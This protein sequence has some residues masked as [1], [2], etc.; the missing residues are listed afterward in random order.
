MKNHR[1]FLFIGLTVLVLSA[2]TLLFFRK[3]S[4]QAPGPLEVLEKRNT[5]SH[6]HPHDTQAPST[7]QG[8]ETPQGEN[9][10]TQETAAAEKSP[11]MGLQNAF[12]GALSL[13][14]TAPE[15]ASDKL[16]A[17]A[18]ELGDGD[19]KWTEYYHLLGHSIVNRPP[20][21]PQRWS[22]PHLRGRGALLCPER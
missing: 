6:P 4:P 5:H 17:I 1:S 16:H 13:S 8:E 14:E 18:A 21:G 20:R 7:P 22:I 11:S 19:P 15:L 2:L 10:P 3:S 9:P 12:Q